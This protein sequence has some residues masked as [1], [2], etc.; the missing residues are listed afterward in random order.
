MAQITNITQMKHTI[1][2]RQYTH[3]IHEHK[4]RI[5]Q[6]THMTYNELGLHDTHDTNVHIINPL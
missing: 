1:D 4:A 5:M 6:S 3:N 2:N